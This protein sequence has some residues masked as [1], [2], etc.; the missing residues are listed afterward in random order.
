MWLYRCFPRDSPS[1]TNPHAGVRVHPIPQERKG[2][3]R[4]GCGVLCFAWRRPWEWRAGSLTQVTWKGAV[5]TDS[6]LPNSQLVPNLGRF[7]LKTCGLCDGV[8]AQ[9][10]G[11]FPSV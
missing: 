7:E 3:G 5:E 4:Q 9:A 6:V 1:M 2:E 11:V 10:I 8:K